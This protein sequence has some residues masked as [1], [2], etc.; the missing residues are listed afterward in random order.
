[1]EGYIS[2]HSLTHSLPFSSLLFMRMYLHSFARIHSSPEIEGVS[3]I[4]IE[5]TRAGG[6]RRD[7]VTLTYSKRKRRR[8]RAHICQDFRYLHTKKMMT[9][10]GPPQSD[11]PPMR[12]AS[13]GNRISLNS[14]TQAIGQGRTN[15]V[16]S[17]PPVSQSTQRAESAKSETF[18]SPNT[19][20][21][22]ERRM[23]MRRGDRL[24]ALGNPTLTDG[25]HR[26]TVARRVCAEWVA[27]HQQEQESAPAFVERAKELFYKVVVHNHMPLVTDGH[28]QLCVLA[29]RAAVSCLLL[30]EI[31][32]ALPRH[33]IL[34]PCIC[35][36][37][38]LVYVPNTEEMREALGGSVQYMPLLRQL[39]EL[40][41]TNTTSVDLMRF[42]RKPFFVAH[43]ELTRSVVMYS[44]MNLT[45]QERFRR[46]PRI[47]DLLNANWIKSF[48]RTILKAWQRVCLKRRQSEQ[49]HRS[50]WARRF[51]AERIRSIIRQWR[52]HAQIRVHNAVAADSIMGRIKALT[53]SVRNTNSDIESLTAKSAQLSEKLCEKETEYER[54]EKEITLLEEQYKEKLRHVCEA[55][56]VGTKLLNT[57]ILRMPFPKGAE[58]M[59]PLELLVLWA[60]TVLIESPLGSLFLGTSD[61]LFVEQSESF[62]MQ[63]LCTLHVADVDPADLPFAPLLTGTA[64]VYL[65]MHCMLALISVL[66][67]GMG[68][69][70]QQIAKVCQMDAVVREV[71]MEI[72]NQVEDSVVIGKK[73]SIQKFEEEIGRT[74]VEAYE[75]FTGNA[76]LVSAEQL[77]TRSRGFQL[78]FLAGLLRHFANWVD[79]ALKPRRP[80]RDCRDLTTNSSASSGY[81]LDMPLES[82]SPLVAAAASSLSTQPI[83][84]NSVKDGHTG[85]RHALYP[86]WFHPPGNHTT[87]LEIVE[88]QQRWIAAS[89]NA[90]HSALN[91]A[92]EQ[93]PVCTVQVQEETPVYMENVTVRRLIDII[94][95]EAI[96]DRSFFYRLA[97]SVES[98]LPKL[99]NIFLQCATLEFTCSPRK[100]EG[101]DTAASGKSSV[102]NMADHT[103]R[104]ADLVNHPAEGECCHY[105]SSLDFWWLLRDCR[106]VG[107]RGRLHRAVVHAIVEKVVGSSSSR[108]TS[109]LEKSS[110]VSGMRRTRSGKELAEIDL[111]NTHYKLR[112]TAPEFVE[113]LL[114]CAQVWDYMQVA[115]QQEET[116]FSSTAAMSNKQLTD[117]ESFKSPSTSISGR[118][119][120]YS[121]RRKICLADRVN[122]REAISQ[123][124]VSYTPYDTSW[125]LRPTAVYEFLNE[126]IIV[127]GLRGPTL[128][129]FQRAKRHPLLRQQFV[130]HGD[131]LF[132]IFCHYAKPREGY[133]I[134][135]V[136][137]EEPFSEDASLEGTV[138]SLEGSIRK[139]CLGGPKGTGNVG[140]VRAMTLANLQAMSVGFSWYGIRRVTP[141]IIE[142]SFYAVLAD[143]ENEVGVI[144][145]PE[146]LDVLCVLA[147]YLKPNPAEPLHEKMAAF[148]NTHVLVHSKSL[149]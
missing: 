89:F 55:D 50:R 93:P 18:R 39:Q 35:M 1:M 71:R 147:Y 86:E 19:K 37:L 91:A 41:V 4:Q 23:P 117:E 60:N 74:V 56:R 144:F 57:L 40:N 134:R 31:V 22:Q 104:H 83:G 126:Y 108:G 135:P 48:L 64:V 27:V 149:Y 125:P 42:A 99:R 11:T 124:V 80:S 118:F 24:P 127:R 121:P 116:Q 145:Y 10:G 113:A 90:L 115:Q 123:T 9:G 139:K 68:P 109:R 2:S 101:G 102:S 54:L 75:A 52:V 25:L 137:E 15:S 43:H 136:E 88:N 72:E 13:P 112:L 87:W 32:K 38:R 67:Q 92:T 47:F 97:R 58:A 44:H 46:L 28:D 122:H 141:Q 59:L 130:T 81:D 114:R 69:N 106:V 131:T 61:K 29:A 78:V 63:D 107:G 111:R 6:W 100:A 5:R 128:D 7:V 98:A 133:G 34:E 94:S 84:S 70:M 140:I 30:E 66:D 33:E 120:T 103:F 53:I 26:L 119:T 132:A 21:R 129:F 36:L 142:E 45:R 65:P 62:I 16:M 79:R 3:V 82:V 146:W 143:P 12:A 20:G 138:S 51:A 77:M 95:P 49:K 14:A 8:N 148:L 17:L 76:S 110:Q 73:K 85:V 105:I 96:A